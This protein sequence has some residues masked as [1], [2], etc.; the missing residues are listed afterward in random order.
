L[1]T[2]TIYATLCTTVISEVEPDRI[3]CIRSGPVGWFLKPNWRKSGKYTITSLLNSDKEQPSLMTDRNSNKEWK[4]RLI[5]AVVKIRSKLCLYTNLYKY[6]RHV[7]FFF[8]LNLHQHFMYSLD[9]KTV[10]KVVYR[11]ENSSVQ[12]RVGYDEVAKIRPDRFKLWAIDLRFP[13]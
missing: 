13:S 11:R 5:A 12:P 8:I 3:F 1:H 10:N 6:F 7:G 9:L 4:L 2:V